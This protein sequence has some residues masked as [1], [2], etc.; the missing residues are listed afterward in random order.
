MSVADI[1][2]CQCAVER[3]NRSYVSAWYASYSVL[4]AGSA[5]PSPPF[6]D[7]PMPGL[8]PATGSETS[9]SPILPQGRQ[10]SSSR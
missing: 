7:I 1:V 5:P 2:V 6:T 3:D 9:S 8:T 10:Y 4:A